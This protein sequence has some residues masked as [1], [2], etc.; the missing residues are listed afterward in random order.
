MLCSYRSYIPYAGS[1]NHT[2]TRITRIVQNLARIL[3][4][5]LLTNRR[6]A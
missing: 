1:V 6:S 5:S 3:P 4:Y 2:K